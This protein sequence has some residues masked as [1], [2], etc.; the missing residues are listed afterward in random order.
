MLPPGLASI[1]RSHRRRD[2][3]ERADRDKLPAGETVTCSDA[4][5]RFTVPHTK[6]RSA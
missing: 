3:Q 6:K 1:L 5:V 2:Q 4:N